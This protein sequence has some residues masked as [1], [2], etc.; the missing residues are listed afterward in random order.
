[1]EPYFQNF[2]EE[3]LQ[4]CGQQSTEKD[5]AFLIP[6]LGKNYKEIWD[7]K[8]QREIEIENKI[9]KKR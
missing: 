3:H 4:M 7:E 9:Q 6:P 1:M 2:T 8:D 5:P